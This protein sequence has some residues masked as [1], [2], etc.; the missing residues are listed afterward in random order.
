MRYRPFG[1]SGS[2]VS[3]LTLSLGLDALAKGPAAAEDMIYSALESGINSYRL[4]TADPVLAEVVGKAL[5]NVDRKLLNVSLMLGTGDGKRG[6]ERDFTAQGM[7]GFIDRA[8]HLSGLGWFDTAILQQPGEDE[9]PQT[10]LNALKALRATERVKFLGI[11]GED[12]VMDTYVSTGAFDVL[13]TPYH[14][15]VD[16]RVQSRVRTAR[17]QDMAI[18]A[19]DYFPESLNS[20]KKVTAIHQPKKGFFGFGGTNKSPL[21]GAGTFAFLHE[22]PNWSAE[23]ICLAHA[24]TNP[25]ICSVII[26]SAD[27]ERLN[28]LAAIPERDM[29]PGLA[30]QIEMA[31]VRTAA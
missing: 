22:T 28:A 2:T 18:V 15:N 6:S 26:S 9:L 17:E 11:A 25:S 10:S 7:T 29:P 1:A 19:Y 3:A 23:A 16:W 4:E 27:A 30:A 14:V 20:I 24:M 8:L 13:L 12:E 31:R 21:A 5:T